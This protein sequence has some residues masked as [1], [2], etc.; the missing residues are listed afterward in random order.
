MQYRVYAILKNGLPL[1]FYVI[2]W[3]LFFQI[4]RVIFILYFQERFHEHTFFEILQI[5]VYSLRMDVSMAGY[6]SAIPLVGYLLSWFVPQLSINK[7]FLTVYTSM[8]IILVAFITVIDFNIYREWGTKINYRV[9]E[10]LFSSFK[11]AL[12][13]SYSSPIVFSVFIFLL[14]VSLGSYLFRKLMLVQLSNPVY[15]ITL[16]LKLPVAILLIGICFLMIR[17]N[18]GV[19]PMNA[20]MVYF[21]D[22]PLLN[23]TALNTEWN[24]IQSVL[25]NVDNTRNPYLFFAHDKERRYW[26]QEVINNNRIEKSQ[27]VSTILRVAKPNIVLIVV[28]SFTADLIKCMGGDKEAAPHFEEW[29]KEGLLFSNIYAAGDRTDKGL[30]AII[31]GFPS[32]ANRRII[33]E[34][35]KQERLPAL[36]SCLKK[37]GYHTSFYYGGELEFSNFKS[38]LLSHA[39]ERLVGKNSFAIR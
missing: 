38:Y 37:N 32:L 15:I 16:Y 22:K 21:S 33:T 31:S 29:R 2:F 28:E 7:R 23:R 26:I 17:G 10:Y 35:N 27:Q 4:N 12:V 5:F 24:L 6:F 8:L 9:F 20:S 3:L 25:E 18:V 30:I 39:Y 1:L 34:N 36:S 14:L 11:E 19:A 13:S